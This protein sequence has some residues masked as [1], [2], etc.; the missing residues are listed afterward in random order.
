MYKYMHTNT[1]KYIPR[2]SFCKE[3][4]TLP[5]GMHSKDMAKANNTTKSFQRINKNNLFRNENEERSQDC[6]SRTTN[7]G[8]RITK[9]STNNPRKS[10]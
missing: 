5:P 2:N 8:I 7:K 6:I 4:K 10:S 1:Y 9:G 3:T